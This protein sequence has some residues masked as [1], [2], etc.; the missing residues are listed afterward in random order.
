MENI[1]LWECI[2][3]CPHCEKENIIEWNTDVM[4]YIIK[5][6]HCGEE[7]LLCDDCMHSPDNEYMYCNWCRTATGGKCFRGETKNS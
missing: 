5:C 3:V 7:I 6:Q 4:G 1:E 2:E